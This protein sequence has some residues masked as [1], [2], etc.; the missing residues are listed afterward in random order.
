M[1]LIAYIDPATGSFLL[2]ALAAGLLAALFAL[3]TFWH[4]IAG[5]FRRGP[6][7]KADAERGD[8]PRD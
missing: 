7:A 2:Q 6:A 1:W 5:F 4:R 3:K 8:G